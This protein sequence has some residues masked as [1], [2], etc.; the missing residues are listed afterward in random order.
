V[1]NSVEKFFEVEINDDVVA[2]GDVSLRLGHRLMGRA[3]R[4]ESVTNPNY[5]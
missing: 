2:L 5:G 1:V 3:S 4:T